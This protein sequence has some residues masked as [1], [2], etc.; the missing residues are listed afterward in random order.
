MDKKVIMWIVIAVLFVIAV[1]T[2][3]QVGAMSSGT[4]VQAAAS[5]ATTAVK[6]ASSGMVGGC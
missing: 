1:F 4:T 5:T 6:T 2:T 3:F